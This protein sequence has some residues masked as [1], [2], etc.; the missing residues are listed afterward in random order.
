[1]SARLTISNEDCAAMVPSLENLLLQ[2]D[3]GDTSLG[4]FIE[5]ITKGEMFLAATDDWEMAQLLA[6]RI[7]CFLTQL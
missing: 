7:G 2:H 3:F 6:H 4:C 5:Q 1:M